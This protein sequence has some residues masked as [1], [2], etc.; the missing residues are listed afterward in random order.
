M[1]YQGKDQDFKP[2]SFSHADFEQSPY[3]AILLWY[4]NAGLDVSE[5]IHRLPD[6]LAEQKLGQEIKFHVLNEAEK[7]DLVTRFRN[8]RGQM[9]CSQSTSAC[10]L[11]CGTCGIRSIQRGNDAQYKEVL[12]ES[13]AE[14]L[15]LNP[16]QSARYN[17]L[18]NMSSIQIPIDENFNTRKIALHKLM[19]VYESGN[20]TYAIHPEFVFKND[21]EQ[22]CT[23]LC[24]ECYNHFV[25]KGE[26]NPLSLAAGT[27]F[28]NASRIGLEKINVF[29]RMLIA[30][31]RLYHSLIKIRAKFQS[32]NLSEGKR[33]TG[34][35]IMFPH[36]APET[37]SFALLLHMFHTLQLDLQSPEI[38]Q[39]CE[40]T[41]SVQFLSPE[42]KIDQLMNNTLGKHIIEAR[43][44]VVQQW[45]LVLQKVSNVGY[46]DDPDVG[47]MTKSLQQL[48]QM[49][50]QYV[51]D[52]AEK[53]TDPTILA[54]DAETSASPHQSQCNDANSLSYSMVASPNDMVQTDEKTK[55]QEK[56]RTLV[57]MAKAC[58]IDVQKDYHWMSKRDT[59]PINQ[60]ML[61]D[62]QQVL[63]N[64]FPDVFPLGITY[65]GK[66][67]SL[68]RTQTRHLLMQFDCQAASC[69]ELL[70]YLFS[71]EEKHNNIIGMSL[72]VKSGKL[73]DFQHL[74]KS[75]EFQD[76]MKEAVK[77][78]DGPSAKQVMKTILPLLNTSKP[79]SQ[80][81]PGQRTKSIAMQ[82]ACHKRFGPASTFVTLAPNLQD[83]PTALRATFASVDN[84]SFP[85][86][87]DDQY[88]KALRKNSSVVGKGNIMLPVG[89]QDR[90]KRA[91]DNPVAMANEYQHL[92]YAVLDILFGTPPDHST[93][94]KGSARNVRTGYYRQK[95]A[96]RKKGIFGHILGYFGT[97]EAQHRG[98]LHFHVIVYGGISPDLLDAAAGIES[99]CAQASNAL[100]TIYQSELPPSFHLSRLI[101]N[102]RRVE[103]EL[104]ESLKQ[105]H[106]H[107]PSFDIEPLPSNESKWQNFTSSI[108]AKTGVHRHTFTCRKNFRQHTHCREAYKQRPIAATYP[109]L[110]KEHP[111]EDYLLLGV[112]RSEHPPIS[113]EEIP[114]KKK[115]CVRNCQ[116]EPLPVPEKHRCIYWDIQRQQLDL[117]PDYS[118]L[119]PTQNSSKNKCI[120]AIQKVLKPNKFTNQAEKKVMIHWF[121]KQH[122][123]L[124]FDI[125]HAL[126]QKLHSANQYVV[127]HNDILSNTVKFNTNVAL[128]GS[129]FQS[130]AALFYLTPYIAKTKMA[131]G[132]AIQ[133][134]HTS[135][136][137]VHKY[138]ST[139]KNSNTDERITQHWLTRTLNTLACQAE[140][141]DQQVAFGLLGFSVDMCSETFSYISPHEHVHL[142]QQHNTQALHK[143][144]ENTADDL[145]FDD[146]RDIDDY[147]YITGFSPFYTT[148][149]ANDETV[150]KTPI[151]VVLHYNY[152]SS[153]LKDL[154]RLEYYTLIGIKQYGNSEKKITS[155][156]GRKSSARFPFHKNHPLYQTH[157]QFI[158]SRQSTPIFMDKPPPLPTQ[159]QHMSP[160]QK[161]IAD[162]FAS[163]W[164]TM[165]RP[166]TQVFDGLHKISTLKYD[167]NAFVQWCNTQEKS[168]FVHERLRFHS[169]NRAVYSLKTDPSKRDILNAYRREFSDSMGPAT[170][171]RACKN[172]QQ[173][174]DIMDEFMMLATD[175]KLDKQSLIMANKQIQYCN[176]Q[177]QA[178]Q[179]IIHPTASTEQDNNIHYTNHPQLT[180]LSNTPH[181][182][183]LENFT[184]FQMKSITNQDESYH[185]L[186]QE[187][188]LPNPSFPTIHEFLSTKE[189]SPDQKD[190]LEKMHAIDI[191]S[192]NDTNQHLCML[193]GKPGAGK[194]YLVETILEIAEISNNCH[195]ITAANYGVAAAS[196]FGTTLHSLFNLSFSKT[197]RQT[198]RS[199][200]PLTPVQL[201]SLRT[202]I[203]HEILRLMMI[204]EFATVDPALFAIV[205]IRLQQV[206]NNHLPF[207]GL[208]L[209][210]IGDLW[211]LP[212]IAGCLAAAMLEYQQFLLSQERNKTQRLKGKERTKF[213]SDLAGKFHIQSLWRRGCE[214]LSQFKHFHLTTQHRSADLSHLHFLES[215]TQPNSLNFQEFCK[216]YKP[217][218]NSDFHEDSRWEFAP[219]LVATNRERIQI[220]HIQAL[221]FAKKHNTHVYR[222]PVQLI[223][224]TNRPS[225]Y[226]DQIE[227][228]KDPAFYQYFVPNAPSFCTNN[229]NTKLGIANG[230]Q[231]RLHSIIP[232]DQDQQ[233]YILYQQ[234]HLPF[235]SII[236]LS[237]PPFA[238]NVTVKPKT[239][240]SPILQHKLQTIA[241][242]LRQCAFAFTEDNLPIIPLVQ[243]SISSL[244]KPISISSKKYTV[245]GGSSFNISKVEV[246]PNFPFELG[247]AMTV[248][249]A[250]GRTLSKVI[251]CLAERPLKLTQMG[252]QSLYVSLSRV[253]F[254]SDIRILYHNSMQNTTELE[255]IA[256]LESHKIV[257]SFFAGFVA[258]KTWNGPV[259][260]SHY[261]NTS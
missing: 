66:R 202:D 211:Q 119:N 241:N 24:G 46:M 60:F 129:R 104:N 142:I 65:P 138:P 128:L 163:F 94:G 178:I 167:W 155:K 27:D 50:N 120:K 127:Q 233:N 218:S 85:A 151:P 53:E 108:V 133:A 5:W 199:I 257:Q 240:T 106:T 149:S 73:K 162:T 176:Q 76:K 198:L 126:R 92:I 80:Y 86:T 209:Y 41:I 244:S 123:E 208:S 193:T 160:R 219:Y 171:K 188:P 203:R 68:T 217:L 105:V 229:L 183:A 255:Y 78:P 82:L 130:I 144:N 44:H 242:Q 235:G 161:V 1:Q 201:Q 7:D 164:L 232:L 181:Y 43:P 98:T 154:N 71:E 256:Y 174:P 177:N 88:I 165:Y 243:P 190:A 145:Q 254:A 223:H 150:I 49:M 220:S 28:G 29:E 200:E 26:V 234:R 109:V 99:L 152:R 107:P 135:L 158:R 147:S 227:A 45:L 207:G 230:T 122:P 168:H 75:K 101:K 124:I 11:S 204:D 14:L 186:P 56:L 125:Y 15:K 252:I 258:E 205:S 118:D 231:M 23:F 213:Q 182:E 189:L 32:S 117:L 51:L 33:M 248:H 42:S 77:N 58:N 100:N 113:T 222:W 143:I 115:Q 261:T 10:M 69:R 259:A 159:I 19:S 245:P 111:A 72:A 8:A 216:L 237:Q 103:T 225:E 96:L 212:A 187:Q 31:W 22:D 195:A 64:A 260:L 239:T 93:I 83:D 59:E 191:F 89:Y 196:V 179:T 173:S 228:Q 81:S 87:T 30:K 246:R 74:H 13:I 221:Q 185:S 236:T 146:D 4:L 169:L 180:V 131:L 39:F 110:L 17:R 79:C 54:Q 38:K 36:N 48:I 9:S 91:S 170:H 18:K 62:P 55:M 121:K 175:A 192:S 114:P 97:H 70:F 172:H 137:H 21:K 6:S 153:A 116:I 141:S 67:I 215:M 102:Y 249:K 47:S 134:L 132:T 95:G 84:V 139:A 52:N 90:A 61:D 16:I 136:Q 148:T 224:W 37:T 253:K 3:R 12:L 63:P 156:K 35:A 34:H 184:T 247:F 157:Y 112:K 214:L 194:S 25:T 140:V 250:Q 2:L 166:E 251:L 238:I 226:D 210:C 40:K 197:K 57:S 20:A 206:F